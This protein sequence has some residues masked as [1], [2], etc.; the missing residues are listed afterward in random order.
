VN[1]DKVGWEIESEFPQI[2]ELRDDVLDWLKSYS[3]YVDYTR[4]GS[5]NGYEYRFMREVDWWLSDEFVKFAR[6]FPF[7]V[8]QE[9]NCGNHLHF[10]FKSRQQY[11]RVIDN[12]FGLQGVYIEMAYREENIK[13]LY[14]LYNSYS[15][16]ITHGNINDWNDGRYWFMNLNS[17]SEHGTLEVRILPHFETSDEIIRWVRLIIKTMNAMSTIEINPL[18]FENFILT[19]KWIYNKMN[20][21]QTNVRYFGREYFKIRAIENNMDWQNVAGVIRQA[22]ESA[23]IKVFADDFHA[24]PYKDGAI[25]L[26]MFR[27]HDFYVPMIPTALMQKAVEV[28]DKKLTEVAII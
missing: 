17:M 7:Y 8:R 26:A 19:G 28:V 14:R 16:V 12:I 11:D 10:S 20:L 1:I 27:V 21:H 24:I 23:G 5:I 13:Y 6:E 25:N 15:K 4:D 9:G 2:H 22:L 3:K 18:G